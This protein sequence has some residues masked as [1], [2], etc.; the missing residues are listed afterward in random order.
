MSVLASGA[1]VLIYNPVALAAVYGEQIRA[2]GQAAA[3][4]AGCRRPAAA[5]AGRPPVM[6]RAGR[7][8]VQVP[9]IM[10]VDDSITVR[11]V[12]QR[13]LQREG[14]RVAPAADGLQALEQLQD[15]RPM[16]CSRTSKCRAW[17]ALTWLRNI[18]ADATPG[19]P[20]D[21]HDHLAHRE[22]HRDQATELGVNHYLGKPY[23]DEELLSISTATMLQHRRS[24]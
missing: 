6:L 9:L 18:R 22:K 1:V 2:L 11:R 16:W 15:E 12:T 3:F 14:Y 19:R 4:G 13:L 24:R 21:D 10:V 5:P 17:T 23:S 8:V 7:S 20:A